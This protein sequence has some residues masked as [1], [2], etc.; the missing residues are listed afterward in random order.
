MLRSMRAIGK[1]KKNYGDVEI[2]VDIQSVN[3]KHCDVH[4]K[5]AYECLAFDPA[6]RKIL[7]EQIERGQI[8]VIVQL[9]FFSSYPAHVRLNSAYAK[10]LQQAALLLAKEL[11]CKMPSTDE[12]TITLLK[13]KGVLQIGFE[14]REAEAL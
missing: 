11:G 3:R 6:I 12:L 10:S 9:L 7:S 1:A 13:E 8:T 5:L 4:C 2:L 14:E